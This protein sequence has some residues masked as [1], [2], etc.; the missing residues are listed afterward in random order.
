MLKYNLRQKEKQII[1]N[2]FITSDPLKTRS[3][4]IM[5]FVLNI[6]LYFV[7]NGLFF[8][9]SVVSEIYNVDES[10]ENF[11]AIYQD[12]LIKLFIQH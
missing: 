2:T 8:S 10:K 12:L 5:L 11:L 6:M 3:M 7:V 4:K 1:A 9:E